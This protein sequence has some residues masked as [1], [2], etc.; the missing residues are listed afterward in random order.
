MNF[1]ASVHH[2]Y[3]ILDPLFKWKVLDTKSLQHLSNYPGRYDSFCEIL[4]NLKRKGL[5]NWDYLV[6]GINK[7]AYLTKEAYGE[8]VPGYLYHLDHRTVFNGIMISNVAR[9]LVEKKHFYDCELYPDYNFKK[10]W[11]WGHILEPNAILFGKS[12]K[13]NFNIAIEVALDQ[14]LKHQVIQKFDAY[15]RS[16][17]F[18][19]AIFIFH[20]RDTFDTYLKMLKETHDALKPSLYKMAI[21]RKILFLFKEDLIK[22]PLDFSECLLFSSSRERKFCEVIMD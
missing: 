18:S 5:I 3:K 21:D 2:Y 22:F 6:Y 7:V 1:C 12:K 13:G 10:N 20:K 17:F 15:A 4:R 11:K 9:S 8:I 14:K 16:E 19:G